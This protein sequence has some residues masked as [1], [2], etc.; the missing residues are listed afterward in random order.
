[1]RWQKTNKENAQ[2]YFN[3][4]YS[5]FYGKRWRTIEEA[6]LSPHNHVALLNN[7]NVAVAETKQLFYSIGA[8]N[9]RDI[10]NEI[11]NGNEN[12]VSDLIIETNSYEPNF[13]QE[14]GKE[15]KI[16]G[17]FSINL[18]NEIELN[19]PEDFDVFIPLNSMAK[20][21][22]TTSN[23]NNI[24]SHFLM[25]G[26]SILP[27]FLLDVQPGDRVY[28][29]CS[30]PGGKSLFLLQTK[31]LL[32]LVCNDIKQERVKRIF[33]L[34][35]AYIPNFDDDWIGKQCEIQRKDARGC[36]ELNCYDKVFTRN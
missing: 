25:D 16:D 33:E 4:N 1:M 20:L 22:R 35:R 14:N 12:I 24:Q 7:F 21:P 3:D 9:I 30:A 28:D 32:F 29:A 6:L 17:H 36:R 5:C 11:K 34:F 10:C 27:P 23:T 26:A 19:F 2:K 13:T 18:E 15:S 8:R 31:H